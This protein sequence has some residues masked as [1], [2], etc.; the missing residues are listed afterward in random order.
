MLFAFEFFFPHLVVDAALSR[1]EMCNAHA[2]V[3]VYACKNPLCHGACKY[4]LQDF[5]AQVAGSEAIAM[6]DKQPVVAGVQHHGLAEYGDIQFGWEVVKHPHI[7]VAGEEVDR[8]SRIAQFGQFALQ[9][10]EAF[11]YDGTVFKP[12]IKNIA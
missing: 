8:Y 5:I 3:G 6:A 10:D 2:K 11:G 4:A 9:A 1:P 12:K 7:V